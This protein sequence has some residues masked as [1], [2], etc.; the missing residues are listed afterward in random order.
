MSLP[1]RSL[2]RVL[3]FWKFE[4]D[5]PAVRRLRLTYFILT[6]TFFLPLTWAFV[7]VRSLYPIASWNLM[8]RGG[9]LQQSYTYFV[10]R[11]ETSTGAMIDIPA[12]TLTPAMRSRIWGLVAATATN[13]SVKLQSP[14]PRNVLLASQ[15]ANGQVPDGVRMKDLLRAWGDEYNERY[16]AASPNRLKAIRIDTYQWSGGAYANYDRFIRS[17]REEL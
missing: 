14:H 8:T 16:S 12:I 15:L 4:G 5:P 6:L 1:K 3:A 11:G 7:R 17:W 13:Q 9:E 10:L 2:Q